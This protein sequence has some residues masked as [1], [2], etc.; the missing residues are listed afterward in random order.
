MYAPLSRQI[1]LVGAL[2]GERR[3][4]QTEG[5][6]MDP[7]QMLPVPDVVLVIADP[8]GGAMLFRYTAHGELAGD[9]PHDSVSAAIEQAADE[10]G[11]AVG[12]W[13]AVPDEVTDAHTFAVQ[14]ALE[15]LD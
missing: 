15:R 12:E 6:P 1:A 14:Y 9:T 7:E 13:V 3:A 11:D 4:A 2:A 5:Y 10:Y 8:L